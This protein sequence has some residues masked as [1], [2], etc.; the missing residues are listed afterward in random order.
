MHSDI[1]KHLEIIKNAVALQ[2]EDLI[3]MQTQTLQILPLDAKAQQILT[4]IT[5]QRFQYVIQLIEQYKRENN[6]LTTF[7]DPQIQGLKLEWKVLKNRTN[8]LTDI[9]ADIDRICN[10]FQNEYMLRLGNLLEEIL[11]LQAETSMDAEE[12]QVYESFHRSHQQELGNL[13]TLLSDDEKQRLKTAYQLASRLCHSTKLTD[14]F[15]MQGEEFF[16]ALNEAYRKQDLKRIEEILAV[17]EASAVWN[18]T[19]DN[20]SDKSVLQQKINALRLRTST[21]EAEIQDLQE[22]EVYQRIQTIE[23]LDR[24]FSELEYKLQSEL[25]ALRNL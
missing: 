1:L 23:N 24:Y 17:L 19:S 7:E 9:Q 13:V 11:K 21:L 5:T 4:L 3:A 16:K 12:Q 22:D 15:K 14:D 10:T 8:E 25:E 6:G 18:A 20:M 2:D